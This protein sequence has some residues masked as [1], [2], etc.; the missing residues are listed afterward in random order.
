MDEVVDSMQES[1]NTVAWLYKGDTKQLV[2]K[3]RVLRVKSWYF[4]DKL[5]CNNL[6]E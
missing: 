2:L 6:F 1:K 4:Q 3:W 5:H